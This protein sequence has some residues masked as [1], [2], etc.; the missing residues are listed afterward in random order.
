[1]T[2]SMGRPVVPW[3]WPR[4]SSA[5]CGAGLTCRRQRGCG[6]VGSW[7]ICTISG[8]R[9]PISLEVMLKRN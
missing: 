2:G 4:A 6:A 8:R 5:C 9:V 7:T 3:T 1:M